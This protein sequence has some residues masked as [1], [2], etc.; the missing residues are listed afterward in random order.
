MHNDSEYFTTGSCV[1]D[2]TSVLHNDIL[3]QVAV[4]EMRHQFCTMI[5]NILQQVAV[6]EMRHQ[7]CTMIV[8]VLQQVAVLETEVS[9]LH[10]DVADFHFDDYQRILHISASTLRQAE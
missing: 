6:L 3:Q 9:A 4:L 1:G 7:S 2:E 8:I 5:V 10:N